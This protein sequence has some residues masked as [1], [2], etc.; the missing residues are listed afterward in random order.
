MSIQFNLAGVIGRAIGGVAFEA[1]GAGWCF[2]INGLSFLAVI[3]SLLLA[4]L[5]SLRQAKSRAHVWL[6]LREGLS[7][8]FRHEVMLPLVVLGVATAFLGIPTMTLVAGLRRRRLSSSGRRAIRLSWRAIFGVGGVLGALVVAWLG[9]KERKGRRALI[10]QIVLGL[11]TLGVCAQH[12]RIWAGAG[13]LFFVGASV[14]FVFASITSLVQLLAPEN[15][16]GR[17]MSVYNTAFRGS[18]ALGPPVSGYLARSFGAPVIVMANG[19][20]LVAVAAGFFAK[21]RRVREL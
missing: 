16:R 18:M 15:M 3:V 12:Q 19:V 7:F 13:L 8:V 2:A 1:L 14:L 5:R 6:S 9:N 17:I 4:A 10:M 20:L 11:A 21:S